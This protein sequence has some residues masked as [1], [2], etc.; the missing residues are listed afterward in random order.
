MLVVIMI[1]QGSFVEKLLKLVYS[2]SQVVLSRK[3]V[4]THSDLDLLS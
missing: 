3:K 2:R 4:Q 1:V